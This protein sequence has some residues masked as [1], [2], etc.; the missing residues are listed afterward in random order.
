MAAFAAPMAATAG[1][2]FLALYN[3][4]HLG[5]GAI[6]GAFWQM[7]LVLFFVVPISLVLSWPLFWAIQRI[8]RRALPRFAYWLGLLT[9]GATF[10]VVLG[11]WYSTQIASWLLAVVIVGLALNCLAFM[12]ARS[13]SNNAMDS[14]TTLSPLR[15]PYGARHRGR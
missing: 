11:V 7:V 9:S 15:A 5:T 6:V 1:I 4:I 3:A 2:A 12:G 14:D 13:S 8:W 10:T